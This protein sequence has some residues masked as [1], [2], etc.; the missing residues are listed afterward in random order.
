MTKDLLDRAGL[1][2]LVEEH[3]PQRRRAVGGEDLADAG[4]LAAG[5]D[6]AEFRA[7]VVADVIDTLRTEPGWREVLAGQRPAT[8]GELGA[9]IA[10]HA[11]VMFEAGVLHG[12]SRG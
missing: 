10:T 3:L 12:E 7:Y 4:L 8:P 2:R 6:P 1:T 11:H 9:L 5:V